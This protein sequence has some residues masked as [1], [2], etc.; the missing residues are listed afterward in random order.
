MDNESM[1]AKPT[2]SG[3]YSLLTTS[4]TLD[5]N[6]A[7]VRHAIVLPQAPPQTFFFLALHRMTSELQ[8]ND[9]QTCCLQLIP[10]GINLALRCE[11]CVRRDTS[12]AA[13]V[14]IQS[15][16]DRTLPGRADPLS[17]TMPRQIA[18]GTMTDGITAIRP[19]SGQNVCYRKFAAR[20]S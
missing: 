15:G 20:I 4:H 10:A 18:F 3:P 17:Q 7:R 2:H 5:S 11:N 12:T 9:L 8:L 16:L 13:W 6:L 1:N 14:M 19:H